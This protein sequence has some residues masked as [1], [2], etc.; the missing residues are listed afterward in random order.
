MLDPAEL[1]ELVAGSGFIHLSW[2]C[3]GHYGGVPG[4]NP[5]MEGLSPEANIVILTG[6]KPAA[7]ERGSTRSRSTAG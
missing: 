3:Q 2:F 5:V 4:T 6:R 7:N 1:R